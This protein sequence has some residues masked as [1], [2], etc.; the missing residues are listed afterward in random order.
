VPK[1][2]DL[3]YDKNPNRPFVFCALPQQPAAPQPEFPVTVTLPAQAA[4]KKV[5]V[6]NDKLR[7]VRSAQANPPGWQTTLQCGSYIAQI[8]ELGRQ[9]DVFVVTETGAVNVAL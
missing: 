1:E 3:E 2:P 9:T 8:L 4:G 5:Q 6:L 7:E